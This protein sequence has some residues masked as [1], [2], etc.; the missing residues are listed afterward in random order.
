MKQVDMNGYEVELALLTKEVIEELAPSLL[1]DEA[2]INDCL[3]RYKYYNKL[4]NDLHVFSEEYVKKQ[5][6]IFPPLD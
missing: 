2:K 6:W 5:G 1:A 4:L 3:E